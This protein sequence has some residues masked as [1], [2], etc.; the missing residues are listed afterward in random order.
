MCGLSRPAQLNG[1]STAMTISTANITLVDFFLKAFKTGLSINQHS[2]TIVTFGFTFTVVKFKYNRVRFTT[3]NTRVGLLISQNKSSIS[4]TTVI[5]RSVNSRFIF[6][7][8]G[9]ISGAMTKTT[10]CLETV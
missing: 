5:S 2:H 6:L 1:R 4:I 7:K 9:T 8:G 3:I 10:V